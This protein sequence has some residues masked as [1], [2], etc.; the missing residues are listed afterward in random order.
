MNEGAFHS[1]YQFIP[2]ARRSGSTFDPDSGAA[3]DGGAGEPARRDVGRR[4][5]ADIADGKTAASH[6]RD[7]PGHHAGRILCAL[8]VESPLLLGA[9]RKQPGDGDQGISTM[10]N[11]RYRGELAVPGNSLRGAVGSLMEG[12]SQSAMRVLADRTFDV[13]MSM[14]HSFKAIGLMLKLPNGAWRLQPLA[15]TGIMVGDT[16]FAD[17]WLRVFPRQLSL[18]DCLTTYFGD[19]GGRNGASPARYRTFQL[20]HNPEYRNIQG[21]PDDLYHTRLGDALRNGVHQITGFKHRDALHY[22]E[23]LPDAPPV[24]AVDDGNARAGAL[25][26]LGQDAQMPRKYHEWFVPFRVDQNNQPLVKQLVVEQSVVNAFTS[27][28]ADSLA[29]EDNRR[30]FIPAGY[31]NRQPHKGVD[32]RADLGM[33]QSGDLVYFDVD[34]SADDGEP[35][36]VTAIGWSAIWRKTVDG[37]LY[38]AFAPGYGDAN[39]GDQNPPDDGELLPW[40]IG[41]R[42]HLTAAEVALGVVEEGG[43][44]G[45]NLASRI[46]FA[47]ALPL[48]EVALQPR[49]PLRPASAPKPPAPSMYFRVPGGSYIPKEQLDLSGAEDHAPNGRKHYLHHR[50]EDWKAAPQ[51]RTGNLCGHADAAHADDPR[52]VAEYDKLGGLWGTP[53][54]PG[55]IF[56][57]H[58]DFN[59]LTDAE[60]HLLRAALDPVASPHN[61]SHDGQFLHKLGWG[62]PLGLGSVRIRRV[63][64]LYVER[65]ERYQ[66]AEVLAEDAPRYAEV[67]VGDPT[68]ANALPERYALEHACIGT[69]RRIEPKGAAASGLVDADTLATLLAIGNPANVKHPVTYPV[70]APAGQEPGGEDEGFAWFVANDRAGSAPGGASCAEA[71]GRVRPGADE[72]LPVLHDHGFCLTRRLDDAKAQDRVLIDR[73]KAEILQR[74]RETYPGE[75]VP[76]LMIH[77]L[78]GSTLGDLAL[79]DPKPPCAAAKLVRLVVS[80]PIT[81][82]RP[83]EGRA[84]QSN[85][86]RRRQHQGHRRR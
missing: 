22:R 7:I 12:L 77:I 23:A 48:G 6:D 76:K 68:L 56:L 85:E 17:K 72:P 84:Q 13:R 70:S 81:P 62:K 35:P 57:F 40:G 74:W 37:T 50:S 42:Q 31:S 5:F 44:P 45:R 59:N 32:A 33:L 11:Y 61:P 75:R 18:G 67:W 36:I 54:E 46:R 73:Q 27:L 82:R 24:L 20:Q 8:S 64:E 58:L 41:R 83:E 21:E 63:A 66:P 29:G 51:W 16:S 79:I 80:P 3:V 47:D 10:K 26:V 60:L 43:E 14:G 39:P 49:V 4:R 2:V 53:I 55:A 19:Y 34:G 52:T 28:A 65:R 71:L 38:K 86:R 1:P 9:D 69:A 30:L 15:L 25:Y 78:R